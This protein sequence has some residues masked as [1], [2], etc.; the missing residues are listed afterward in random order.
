MGI[1]PQIG[2]KIKNVSNHH[3]VKADQEETSCITDQFGIFPK[4]EI[5]DL[6]LFK[7]DDFLFHHFC[8]WFRLY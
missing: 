8:W 1:F 7:G 3:L 2:M 4:N 6:D 5:F